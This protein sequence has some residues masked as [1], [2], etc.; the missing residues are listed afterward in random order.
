ME[1]LLI[2]FHMEIQ[3]EHF[4]Q[5]RDLSIEGNVFKFF[6]V[7]GKQTKTHFYSFLKDSKIQNA[8]TT[9]KHMDRL[10]KILKK[11]NVLKDR[12]YETM[13]G[14]GAQY[15]SATA[16]WF[17]SSL[18]ASKHNMVSYNIVVIVVVVVV[19]VFT[20]CYCCCYWLVPASADICLQTDCFCFDA[21][22]QHGVSSEAPL[23]C[24][25]FSTVSSSSNYYSNHTD[26]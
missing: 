19:V 7:W 25:N 24:S 4:G 11:K 3:S 8:A 9:D 26:V 15:R 5:G 16:L 1:R 17:L 18:S 14:C 6:P 20:I 23:F 2:K 21:S 12:L 22:L 13:D 10:T